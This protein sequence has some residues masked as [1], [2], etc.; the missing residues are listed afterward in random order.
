[1]VSVVIASRL[2]LSVIVL[3]RRTMS[4]VS[5]VA[6]SRMVPIVVNILV[7]FVINLLC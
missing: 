6:R 1:M 4:D 7:P 5:I 3:V 2:D